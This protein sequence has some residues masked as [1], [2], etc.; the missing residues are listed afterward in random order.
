MPD[1][2]AIKKELA[3]VRE[4]KRAAIQSL[5]RIVQA[6]DAFIPVGYYGGEKPIELEAGMAHLRAMTE[7]AK[8]EPLTIKAK[9]LSDIRIYWQRELVGQK[10][11][12][13]ILQG[14]LV[15][16]FEDGGMNTVLCAEDPQFF[17]S[18]IIPSFAE[19]VANEVEA[20]LSG[21]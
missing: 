15:G 19:D 20:G 11:Y 13:A 1:L 6:V 2:T 18:E 8:K 7:G 10:P 9:N 17:I 3:R 12:L 5:Q 14:S 4:Q 21:E 16:R